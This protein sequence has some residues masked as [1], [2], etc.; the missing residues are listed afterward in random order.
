MLR[1]SDA[2]TQRDVS[3]KIPIQDIFTSFF[4]IDMYTTVFELQKIKG[5]KLLK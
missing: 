1:I 3:L 2:I 4:W 5:E